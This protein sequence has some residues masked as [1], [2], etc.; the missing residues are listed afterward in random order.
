MSQDPYSDEQPYADE[1]APAS[2]KAGGGSK[3]NVPTIL[4]SAGVAAVVSALVVTIGVVGL[5]TS[6][7]FGS[8]NA[9]PQPTVV[10]LGNAATPGAPTAPTAPPN[11][12]AAPTTVEGA[13]TEE[14]PES[15]G[16]AGAGSGD[17]APTTTAQTQPTQQATQPTTKVA[18]APLTAGQL[19]TKIKTI[20]N[21]AASDSVRADEME[22]GQRALGS[23]G[24]VAQMLRVSGAGFTYK[25]VGPVTQ[26]GETLNARLQMSLVGNGSRYLDLSW[27][28]SDGKWKLSNTSVCAVAAYARLPCTVG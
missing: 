9:E 22:G 14:V 10:N 24:A 27:V 19:N 15:P 7:R 2:T 6:D 21:T 23:V 20:M 16:D 12:A 17:A 4:A 11:G 5:A 1:P 28:W 8:N 3:I 25:V 18:P 13:P 26:N